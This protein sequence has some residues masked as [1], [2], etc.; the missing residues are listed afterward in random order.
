MLWG[1]TSEKVEE[2][3]RPK[4]IRPEKVKEIMGFAASRGVA[5]GQA[6]VIMRPAELSQVQMDEILVCPASDPTW[7][8]AFGRI[9]AIVT[10]QGGIMSHAAIVCREYGVP[11]V[12][13]TTIGTEVIRTGDY[14]KVDGD[15]GK[16]S[17]LKQAA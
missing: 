6:R 12:T 9:K 16:V 7:S 13:N 10:N 3:L 2:A 1:V 5:E 14:I 8:S 17:I 11:C 4:E 15:S